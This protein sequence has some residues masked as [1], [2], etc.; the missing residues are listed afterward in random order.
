MRL[1]I[2]TRVAQ[3]YRE[4][5]A[6]F[7]RELFLALAPPFP[8]V[9]LKRFDGCNEGDIVHLELDMIFTK[10]NWTSRIVEKGESSNNAVFRDEVYFI[11]EGEQLPFF[12]RYWRH[13]H[14]IMSNEEGST[15]VD[16]IEFQAFGGLDLLLYPVLWLQFMY[17]KPVYKRF[18][19]SV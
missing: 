14:R 8:P 15:V 13:E 1:T 5:F 17:R 18:F 16:A 11:D 9:A 7:D 3:P 2:R 4:V 10:Q 12:L 6:R 19:G